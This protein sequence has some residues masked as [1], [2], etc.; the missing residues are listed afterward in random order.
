MKYFPKPPFK[1]GRKYCQ[2]DE[3]NIILSIFDYIGHGNTLCDIGARLLLSNSYRLINEYGYTGLLIDADPVECD[4][5]RGKVGNRAEVIEKKITIGNVNDYVGDVDFLSI[6][7]DSNDW[8]IWAVIKAKPRIVCIEFNNNLSGLV[9][10]DYDE[11]LKKSN[12]NN[13]SFDAMI[14]LGELKG[15]KLIAQ[16]GVNAIFVLEEAW[17]GSRK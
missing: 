9:I 1:Y 15:Y 12:D 8:W 3:E 13:A 4:R 10:R 11:N 6:D 5:L 14:L 16:T 17:R 2:H 7:I